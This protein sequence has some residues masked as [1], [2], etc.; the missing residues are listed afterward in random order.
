MTAIPACSRSL[1]EMIRN[2]LTS[3]QRIEVSN[4]RI[5]DQDVLSMVL[6]SDMDKI[7]LTLEEIGP[8]GLR[9]G[10]GR[11][12]G[13]PAHLHPGR[14]LLGRPGHLPG[15]LLQPDFRQCHRWCTPT[16]P[17]RS[18]SSCFRVGAEDVVIGVSFPRYSSRTV[19]AMKFARDRGAATIAITDSE[20][21]PLAPISTLHP[22]GHERYGL[23][24]GLPGGPAA[25]WSTPC[26][27]RSSREEK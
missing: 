16:P 5:G 7:R 22:A 25:A 14:A 11:H 27:W 18:S 24:R 4:D 15:L 6:Q 3:V 23:L 2:R 8:G 17:A 12:R 26:W 19:K 10:G 20:A 1:Q 21:S 13:R 9:P